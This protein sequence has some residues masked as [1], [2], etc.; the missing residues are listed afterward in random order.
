MAEGLSQR[1]VT[2]ATRNA[3]PLGENDKKQLEAYASRM[4]ARVEAGELRSVEAMTFLRAYVLWHDLRAGRID[5]DQP[6]RDDVE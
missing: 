6:A 5:V 3:R 1:W 2:E 4:V